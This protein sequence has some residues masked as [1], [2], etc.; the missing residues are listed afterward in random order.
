MRGD[1][2]RIE[3]VLVNLLTNAIKYNRAG[4]QV[5]IDWAADGTTARI[6]VRDTGQGL[7]LGAG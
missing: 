6:N 4:G 5:T 7:T 1:P 2:V 3:Q